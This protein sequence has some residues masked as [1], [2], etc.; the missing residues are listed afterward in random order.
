MYSRRRYQVQNTHHE[1]YRLPP[2]YMSDIT[3]GIQPPASVSL[4]IPMALA[5]TMYSALRT[6]ALR[7]CELRT[8]APLLAEACTSVFSAVQPGLLTIRAKR[9]HAGPVPAREVCGR[10][11][12]QTSDIPREDI[13]TR[14]TL[15]PSYCPR[16]LP[17]PRIPASPA[18]YALHSPLIQG[19]FLAPDLLSSTPRA[20]MTPHPAESPAEHAPPARGDHS[21]VRLRDVEQR[22]RYSSPRDR[23]RRP[24]GTTP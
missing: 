17:T 16:L 20:S 19:L 3:S 6:P 12:S 9:T 4:K 15:R 22:T 5:G 10:A 11:N 1:T 18:S 2:D 13:P 8:L 21:D 23:Q 7:T 24:Y 14:I